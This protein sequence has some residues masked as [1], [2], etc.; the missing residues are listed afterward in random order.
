LKRLT[1]F[2]AL[3]LGATALTGCATDGYGH[4]RSA[5]WHNRHDGDRHHH[6]DGDRHDRDR[7]GDHGNVWHRD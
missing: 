2:G 7:D 3:A 4:G 5:Y 6:H 1:I